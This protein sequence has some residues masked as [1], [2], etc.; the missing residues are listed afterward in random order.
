MNKNTLQNPYKLVAY[1]ADWSQRKTDI[2]NKNFWEWEIKYN[3]F[4]VPKIIIHE[5]INSKQDA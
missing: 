1:R 5:K 4:R 3:G 2:N